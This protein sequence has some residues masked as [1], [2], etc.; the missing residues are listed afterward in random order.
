[1]KEI[2]LPTNGESF[3][4]TAQTQ[5]MPGLIPFMPFQ[6]VYMPIGNDLG[7]DLGNVRSAL[8]CSNRLVVSKKRRQYAAVRYANLITPEVLFPLRVRRS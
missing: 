1:V 8:S 4:D 5:D 2:L 3:A 7:M 6:A